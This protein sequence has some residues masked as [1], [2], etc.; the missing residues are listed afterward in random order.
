M[1]NVG[2]TVQ[3]SWTDEKGITTMR[4]GDVVECYRS[5]T[6]H[7][8]V[9]GDRLYAV[10]WRE[11]QRVERGYLGCGLVKGVVLPPVLLIPPPGERRRGTT[12]LRG[13]PLDDDGAIEFEHGPAKAV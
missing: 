6:M 10:R 4:V 1:L 11:T 3:R 7:S 5:R 8:F 12:P 2:D 9:Q 13:R